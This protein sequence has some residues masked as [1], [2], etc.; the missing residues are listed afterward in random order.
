VSAFA[1][2]RHHLRLGDPGADQKIW[3]GGKAASHPDTR[4]F[5]FLAVRREVASTDGVAEEL[6][7][8]HRFRV[9]V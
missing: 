1:E 8:A 2:Q 6:G 9:I 3:H 7:A 5:A 4:R